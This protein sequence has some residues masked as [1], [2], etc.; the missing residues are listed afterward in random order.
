MKLTRLA[1]LCTALLIP[2]VS[3]AQQ[4]SQRTFLNNGAT[5]GAAVGAG[6][7]VLLVST[8]REWCDGTCEDGMTGGGMV[9]AMAGGALIGAT[10]GWLADRDADN[11]GITGKRAHFRIGPTFAQSW[12]RSADAEGSYQTKGVSAIL[13]AS[14]HVR[15]TTEYG[16]A[17]ATIP[18][19]PRLGGSL[20]ETVG[21]RIPVSKIGVELVAGLVGEQVEG[22]APHIRTI[23][24]SDVIV[25]LTKHFVVAPGVRMTGG[26]DSRNVSAGLSLQYRF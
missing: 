11:E 14:P 15:F 9:M 12:Y 23:F 22:H 24:G 13:E 2:A 19:G 7:T 5:S 8:L 21:V 1:A 16:Y 4:A 3:Q 20:A 17:G 26:G 6:A 10:V 25:P 18:G